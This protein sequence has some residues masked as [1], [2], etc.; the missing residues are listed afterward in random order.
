MVVKPTSIGP[1][2]PLFLP[3]LRAVPCS[4]AVDFSLSVSSKVKF[5]KSWVRIVRISICAKF[6]PMQSRGVWVNGEKR[7]ECGFRAA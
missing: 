2:V 4:E 6:L 3:R 1:I 5:L 7:R